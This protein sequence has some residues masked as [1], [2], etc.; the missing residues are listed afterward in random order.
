[1]S[2]N[3]IQIRKISPIKSLKN[4]QV[5]KQARSVPGNE[6]IQKSNKSER[7]RGGGVQTDRQIG[8]DKE[9]DRHINID[10]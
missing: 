4:R 2:E 1:M 7:E 6:I 10:G 9:K 3:R 8:G 5:Q